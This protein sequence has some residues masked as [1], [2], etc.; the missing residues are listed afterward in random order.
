[1]YPV[2]RISH[3]PIRG[4]HFAVSRDEK[5]IVE[6]DRKFPTLEEAQA[7]VIS[8]NRLH[9]S[10][11]LGIQGTNDPNTI[12]E[13]CLDDANYESKRE[14]FCDKP[15]NIELIKKQLIENGIQV[16]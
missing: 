12:R 16:L 10:Y 8:M 1:M 14:F 4:N 5:W 15:P 2:Y 6:I 3:I 9:C 7:Y 11:D 13:R